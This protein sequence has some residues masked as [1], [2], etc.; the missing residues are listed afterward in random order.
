MYF[1]DPSFCERDEQ[2]KLFRVSED[3][4]LIAVRGN[5]GLFVSFVNQEL[6]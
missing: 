1:H 4:Y 6:K 2:V 5:E 3:N